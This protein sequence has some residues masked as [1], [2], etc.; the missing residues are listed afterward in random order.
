MH[1]V[2]SF[3]SSIWQHHGLDSQFLHSH[4]TG[5]GLIPGQ[6]K[7]ELWQTKWHWEDRLFSPWALQLSPVSIISPVLHIRLHLHVAQGQT[8]EAWE[9]SKKQCFQK[10]GSVG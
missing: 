1:H 5:P 10:L 3:H 8:G 4:C 2:D 6:S 7:W 9:P